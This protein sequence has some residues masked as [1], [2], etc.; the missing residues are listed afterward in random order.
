M[1]ETKTNRTE[2]DVGRDIYDR[3][4]RLI[5]DKDYAGRWAL[6]IIIDPY[7]QRDDGERIHHSLTIE[8]IRQ[9]AFALERYK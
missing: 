3:R 7:N 5:R 6:S 4:V 2:F 8:N 9:M 1:T